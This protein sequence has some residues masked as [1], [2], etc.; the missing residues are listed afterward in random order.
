MSGTIVS[1]AKA[2]RDHQ[3]ITQVA[4]FAKVAGR[5]VR[6]ASLSPRPYCSA[7]HRTGALFEID[8]QFL[9]PARAPLRPTRPMG[10]IEGRE[11]RL[12]EEATLAAIHV[13]ITKLRLLAQNI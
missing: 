8:P 10:L 9:T 5:A 3:K 11:H 12:G 6:I 7:P 2:P 4:T 13:A 1:G